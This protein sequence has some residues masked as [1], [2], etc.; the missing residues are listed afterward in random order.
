ML[1][2]LGSLIELGYSTLG[3]NRFAWPWLLPK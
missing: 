2:A 1:C 3:R